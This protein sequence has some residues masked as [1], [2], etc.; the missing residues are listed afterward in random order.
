MGTTV[1]CEVNSLLD[2]TKKPLFVGS[3]GGNCKPYHWYNS[4]GHYYD[5]VLDNKL[6]RR[7]GIREGMYADILLTHVNRFSGEV[8]EIFPKRLVPSIMEIKP[9]GISKYS[10]LGTSG[11]LI[12]NFFDDNFFAK[13]VIEI[14][15]AYSFR[16]YTATLTL[17]RKLVENL[18][19]ELLR[20]KFGMQKIDLFYWTDKG[21]ITIFQN[22]L[23]IWKTIFQALNHIHN[24]LKNL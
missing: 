23:K 10:T 20:T 6:V 5:I 2:S 4:K 3:E 7:I 21:D 13:L 15:R 12:E 24:H 22:W 16:L 1:H 8:E 9:K 11:T 18:I 14:N 17:L 19:I